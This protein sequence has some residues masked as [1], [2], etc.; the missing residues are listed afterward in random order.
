MISSLMEMVN[1][2]RLL[3]RRFPD[4]SVNAGCSFASVF[5]HSSDGKGFAAERV[6]E[7]ALQGFHL[8]PLARLSCLRDT[9]LEPTNIPFGPTPV[10]LVPVQRPVGGCTNRGI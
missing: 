1:G 7:Q 8:S 9:N 4:F 6:G 10:N 3:F 2:C 5:C